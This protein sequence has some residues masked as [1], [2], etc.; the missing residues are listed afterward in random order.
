MRAHW[1]NYEKQNRSG[2]GK[3]PSRSPTIG[4]KESRGH[5]SFKGGRATH[6]RDLGAGNIILQAPRR[7]SSRLKGGADA[8][9]SQVKC[10]Q[11]RD[12]ELWDP[13]N[14]PKK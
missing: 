1:D 9:R 7:A 2:P 14:N 3:E 8:E 5:I 4:A 12:R 13:K 11:L 10:S 6:D